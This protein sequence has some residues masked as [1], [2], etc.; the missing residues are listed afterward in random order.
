MR[1]ERHR[2]IV[3]RS[4]ARRDREPQDSIHRD[5]TRS[6][7]VKALVLGVTG[8]VGNAVAR[9]FLARGYGVTGLSRRGR[10]RANLEGLALNYVRGDIDSASSMEAWVRGQEVVVDAAAPYPVALPE[11]GAAGAARILDHA[12]RRTRKLLRAVGKHHA[13]LVYVSS[14]GTLPQSR[15]DLDRIA[16]ALMQRSHPYFAVKRQVEGDVL[17]AA[18]DGLPVVVVNPTGCLG[19]WDYKDRKRCFVPALLRGEM[20]AATD[21]MLNVIDVRDVAIGIVNAIEQKRYGEP[22]PLSGHNI[23]NEG[24]FRW[25]CEVGGVRAPRVVGSSGAAVVASY[26]TEISLRALHVET[27]LPALIAMLTYM[28]DYLAPS[29]AQVDLGVELR[30]L[31]QTLLDSIEWYRSIG[32]C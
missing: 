11:D 6:D 2:G 32:Y 27:P 17:E 30:P 7:P 4:E 12:R 19:P 22:I 9:E 20:P 5:S 26:L 3:P 18:R 29:A 1:S 14:F 25:I 13:R 21:Q 10:S 15:T 16:T 28:H 23:S 24:L 31:S 8:H